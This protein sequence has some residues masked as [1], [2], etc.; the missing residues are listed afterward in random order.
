MLYL[1]IFG[2]NIEDRLGPWWFLAFYL[3]CG[4][5]A[6]PRYGLSLVLT[7]SNSEA[8]PP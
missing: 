8:P 4:V 7:L 6:A 3:T 2:N 1:A 5:A